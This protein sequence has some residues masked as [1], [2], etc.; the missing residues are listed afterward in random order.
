M[1]SSLAHAKAELAPDSVTAAVPAESFVPEASASATRGLGGPRPRT[2]SRLRPLV[3]GSSDR[4]RVVLADRNT[5]AEVDE[6]RS[7][8]TPQAARPK[9]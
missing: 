5:I 4:D 2:R 3:W 1:A 6:R 8:P 7:T 9:G